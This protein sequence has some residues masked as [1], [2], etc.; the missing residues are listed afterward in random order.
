VCYTLGSLVEARLK[1]KKAQF[2]SDL[3]SENEDFKKKKKS[4]KKYGSSSKCSL[5]PSPP[6]LVT[7]KVHF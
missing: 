5:I 4:I 2:L 1:A 7:S 6:S 3:S